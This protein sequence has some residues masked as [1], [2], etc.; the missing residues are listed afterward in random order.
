[1]ASWNV[2]MTDTSIVLKDVSYLLPDGSPLFI[3]LCE[4]FDQRPTGLVGRNG[5]GKSV[6]ARILAGLLLP[7]SGVCRCTGRVHYLA[8]QV[9]LSADQS[10]AGLAGVAPTLEALRRIE[11]GSVADEDFDI[12]GDHW[13]M[14]QRLQQ[15]LEREQ[16]G[17][18]RPDAP[19][20]ALSGGEAMRLSLLGASLSGADFLILDEPSNHLDRE[21][22]QA[23]MAQLQRWQRGLIVISHDRHLLEC[24]TRIVELSPAGLASYGGN[25]GFYAAAKE[26]ER[27]N[28]V[29][30]LHAC[31]VERRRQQRVAQA[32]RERVDRRQARGSRQGKHANQ[33]K[34]LLDRQRERSEASSGALRKKQAASHEQLTLR[35][36]EAARKVESE[37][38]I[39]LHALPV[40][41]PST[42]RVVELTDVQLPYVPRPAG[43]ISLLVRGQ[44]RTGVVGPNGVGKS[45][46]LRVL[47]GELDPLGGS[48]WVTA[49]MAYL[50]QN[51][52]NLDPNGCVWDQLR[53][54]NRTTAEGELRT[55]LAR[56]GL[57]GQRL[58]IASRL[59]SGGERVKAAL[60]CVLYADV[61]PRLLLL[62]EPCNHLDLPS[63]QAVE[64]MLRS[65]GGAMLVVSH[66][67]AFLHSLGL[68]DWLRATE[69][70]WCSQPA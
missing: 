52:R 29:E 44:Q 31:Q 17:Y 69:D 16:L 67:D 1:M 45:T 33:A 65:Y 43:H 10:V 2:R 53:S 42:R 14:P 30:H 7:T 25:Y 15:A 57:D 28:A 70:G 41:Q 59:L 22:R 11:S 26:H 38:Q 18:L 36:H 61:P 49:E 48:C 4:Q 34:I 12:V 8:Q 32:Q 39:L 6:L 3:D 51:L 60:A 63:L 9:V 21:S 54:V 5:V 37:A 40:V 47:A 19:A 13:D 23:L 50:D 27:Q 35:V 56:L 68:T 66:D 46:L 62:D 20:S 64:E 58:A 55:R 24:M